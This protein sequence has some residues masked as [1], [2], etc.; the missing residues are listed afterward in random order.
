MHAPKLLTC[1]KFWKPVTRPSN[2]QMLVAKGNRAQTFSNIWKRTFY[3]HEPSFQQLPLKLPVTEQDHGTWKA[4]KS[5]F[6]LLFLTIVAI[7][8]WKCSGT[9]KLVP[10]KRHL[11]LTK[12]YSTSKYGTE[13]SNDGKNL[14][15]ESERNVEIIQKEM[16]SNIPRWALQTF[17][18]IFNEIVLFQSA[19]HARC[20]NRKNISQQ[21]HGLQFKVKIRHAIYTLHFVCPTLDRVLR[22]I[23]NT[24]EHSAWTLSSN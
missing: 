18:T 24:N 13:E 10:E 23:L 14:L 15:V 9:D 5:N 20:E 17:K 6:I 3:F 16:M 12:T 8:G 22:K 11:I 4:K 7:D 21:N 1:W 2:K 19:S